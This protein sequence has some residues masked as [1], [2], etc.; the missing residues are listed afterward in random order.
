MCDVN[1]MSML[2]CAVLNPINETSKTQKRKNFI[3][4]TQ[5]KRLK[6]FREKNEQFV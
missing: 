2:R 3:I 1:W 5:D 4:A 6:I